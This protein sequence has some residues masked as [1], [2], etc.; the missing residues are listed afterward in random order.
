MIIIEDLF[1]SF[2]LIQTDRLVLRQMENGDAEDLYSFYSDPLVTKHLD[3]GGPSTIEETR[4]IIDTWNQS[5]EDRKLL[6]WGISSRSD[7][8]IIGTILLMPTRG[9]FEEVPRF[10]LTVGYDLSP[11]FWNKGIVSEALR[12]VLDFSRNKIGPHRIQAEVLPDN[13][14]S[15]KV[16][17]K[18]GFQEEGLFRHYLMHEVTNNFLDVVVLALLFN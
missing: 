1:Y 5:F 12:A 14:A 9:T 15:L 8:K 16:L 6:P 11:K 7:G 3:W 10:P 18:L 2:P 13:A 4:K 17:K